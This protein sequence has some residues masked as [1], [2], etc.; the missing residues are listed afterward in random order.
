MALTQCPDCSGELSTAAVACPHC[1]RPN[2]PRS[3]DALRAETPSKGERE[4]IPGDKARC[5]H[6]G[7]ESQIRLPRLVVITGGLLGI[8]LVLGAVGSIFAVIG[9]SNRA[10]ASSLET[11]AKPDAASRVVKSIRAVAISPVQ[12]TATQL[13]Q[14]YRGNSASADAKYRGTSLLVAGSIGWVDRDF[15]DDIVLHLRTGEGSDSIMATVNDADSKK[16][17]HLMNGEHVVL[18]CKGKTRMGLGRP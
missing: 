8:C 12:I 10:T 18:L 11:T 4:W 14:E 7:R 9:K 16:A 6:C 15:I 1:G 13:V 2:H 3:N 17:A 5:P